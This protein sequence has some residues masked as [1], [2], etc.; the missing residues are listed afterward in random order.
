MKCNE[1]EKQRQMIYSYV[2]C[3]AVDFVENI[4]Q[5]TVN[6]SHWGSVIL[7]LFTVRTGFF[8]KTAQADVCLTCNHII[9]Y[10]A[11]LIGSCCICSQ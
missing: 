7:V 4:F 9:I 10:K 2:F 5:L 6:S 3:S 11:Q 8:S 1:N